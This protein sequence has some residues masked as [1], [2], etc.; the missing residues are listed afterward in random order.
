MEAAFANGWQQG[1]SQLHSAKTVP[2]AVL[3]PD[4]TAHFHNPAVMS[5]DNLLG[6]LLP[7]LKNN[8]GQ[9]DNHAKMENEKYCKRPPK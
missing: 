8:A 2:P 1:S 9:L 3:S 6:A 4:Q 7:H 5:C